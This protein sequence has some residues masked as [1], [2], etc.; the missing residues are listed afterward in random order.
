M[1]LPTNTRLR[2]C[3]LWTSAV[4]LVVE[5]VTLFM[6]FGTGFTVTE[7][8][9]TAPLLLQIHHMFWSI[10]VLL[11]LFVLWRRP[12]LSGALLGVAIGFIVSDLAHHFVVLPITVGHTG[13]HWP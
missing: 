11:P 2:A 8:N 6:R 10:P 7:F 9:K 4:T 3:L 13:W 5:A 12:H 1:T